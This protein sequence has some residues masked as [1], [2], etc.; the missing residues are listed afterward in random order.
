MLSWA[1]EQGGAPVLAAIHEA[2][3]RLRPASYEGS[4]AGREPDGIGRLGRLGARELARARH[5]GWMGIVDPMLMALQ[6][7]TIA[8]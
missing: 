5:D 1:I 2:A 7:P 8:A 4:S 3:D 6:A